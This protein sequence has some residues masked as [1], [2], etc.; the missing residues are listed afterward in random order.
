MDVKLCEYIVTITDEGS[1][2][3]AANKLYLTQS[4]LNQQL[5][6]L[7]K[8]LG[9]PLF[10]RNRSRWTLTP[11]GEVYVAGARQM[12]ALQKDTYARISDLAEH[13]NQTVTIGLTAERGMQMFSSIYAEI[14]Q[15]YPHTVF[16]PVEA[17][18]D[19]QNRLLE[20][21]QLDI[22][23]Q[24][25]G[26]H[27]YKSLHYEPI[28]TE[29]FIL[30][31]PKNQADGLPIAKSP[32]DFPQVNLADFHDRVFTLVKPT[33]TMRGMIN[34]LFE[35][36]GFQPKLLFDS[37]GMRSM[38]KLAAHGQCCC[39]IPRFYAIP[40]PDVCYYSLGKEAEWELSTVWSEGHYLSQ[41]ARG[42]IAV[43]KDYWQTHQYVE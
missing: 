9:A 25:I 15:K 5:L 42:F 30:C 39:I 3:A 32:G 17:T 31:V 4:A 16:Q 20:R 10:A 37:V 23:F 22:G 35:Q 14:H 8:E 36:A 33:S 34:R 21:G 12:L 18:V 27:K 11:V 2:S 6:K 19:Q 38:Q 26:D 28:I 43:A 24:T 40:S 29:P 13:W 7:E 41:A 1:I